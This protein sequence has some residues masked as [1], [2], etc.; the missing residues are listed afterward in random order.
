MQNCTLLP[1]LL[2]VSDAKMCK[3]TYL[4]S[5]VLSVCD[6]ELTRNQLYYGS[7][8]IQTV[9]YLEIILYLVKYFHSFQ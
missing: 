8:C 3:V 5:E 1:E 9:M 4:R 2:P 7:M 6:Y